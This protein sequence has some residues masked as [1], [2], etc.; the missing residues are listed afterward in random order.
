MMLIYAYEPNAIIVDPLWDRTKES[1]LQSYQKIIG[2]LTK[3]GL[4]PRLKLLDNG[5]L[6]LL[7]N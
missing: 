5:A 1:I 4:K 6:Q 3:R 2:H 7:Q